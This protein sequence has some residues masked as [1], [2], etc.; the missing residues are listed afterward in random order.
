MFNLFRNKDHL[1]EQTPIV[2]EKR[3]NIEIVIESE[4]ETPLFENES[5]QILLGAQTLLET[6]V[7]DNIE[8][9]IITFAAMFRGLKYQETKKAEDGKTIIVLKDPVFQKRLTYHE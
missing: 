4:S 7:A 6:K 8:D 1:P 2:E 5:E 3:T 9:A